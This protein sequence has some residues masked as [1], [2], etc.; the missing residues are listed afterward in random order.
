MAF[1][2]HTLNAFPRDSWHNI[3]TIYNRDKM[4]REE[5]NAIHASPSF[6][7]PICTISAFTLPSL[8]SALG[9]FNTNMPRNTLLWQCILQHSLWP[10]SPAATGSFARDSAT[11]CLGLSPC[12]LLTSPHPSSLKVYP[13]WCRFQTSP[14]QN[15]TCVAARLA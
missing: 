3:S 9:Y 15:R 13:S 2:R 11:C 14:E 1:T 6:S 12:P 10:D 7:S 8:S 5:R 4:T